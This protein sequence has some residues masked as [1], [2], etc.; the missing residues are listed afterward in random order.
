VLIVGDVGTIDQRLADTIVK[1]PGVEL[2]GTATQPVEALKLA[3]A[4]EPDVI[5]VDGGPDGSRA[6]FW[7]REMVSQGPGAP[8][9][10][11]VPG[12]AVDAA[13]EAMLAGAR[14][15]VPRPFM[16]DNLLR[17]L[18]QVHALEL[19]RRGQPGLTQ[20]EEGAT[21]Q[22]GWIL[23][24]FAPRGGAGRTT[25]AI[26]LAVA[27]Q[28][29][30][31]QVVLVDGAVQFGDVALA[32]NVRTPYSIM[33]LL[34][35]VEELDE[36]FVTGVLAVHSSG[37]RVLAASGRT[38]RLEEVRPESMRRVLG[39]L[40]QMFDYVVVDLCA[41][42]DETSLTVLEMADRIVL[43]LTPDIPALRNATVF[44][45]LTETL[46]YS[47]EKVFVVMNKASSD[48]AVK[49]DEVE[50]LL[51]WPASAVIANDPG[52]VGHALNRGVP[53]VLSH[54]TSRAARDIVALAAQLV[55]SLER[56]KPPSSIL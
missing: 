56:P 44:L 53:L 2:L 14:M 51:G 33:D 23:V 36:D 26:N 8:V 46:R 13:H 16:A 45:E 50:D 35:N 54:P 9:V 29:R 18:H 3:Q 24:V 47:S 34:E 12:A 22:G 4:E 15:F 55:K 38:E 40:R 37:I 7:T 11:V 39:Q 42:L 20:P 30:Y 25:V 21:P 17:T 19:S 43:L 5:L 49:P 32:L 52:P 6:T 48:G 31:R 1:A 28:A 41:R 27:L 10:V